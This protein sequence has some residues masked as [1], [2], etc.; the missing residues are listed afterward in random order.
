MTVEELYQTMGGSYD[1]AR[2]VLP[3]DR[4]IEKFILRFLEDGS[5]QKLLD[6]YAAGDPAGMFEGA[7]ALKGVCAN[8]GLDSLSAKASEIAEE[9]RPG[10]TPRLDP[11]ALAQRMDDLKAQAEAT[12]AAIRRYQEALPR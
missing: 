2:R 7:H 11:Q 9:F 12:Q 4:L 3:S 8:L 6:A 10:N 5:C 1:S